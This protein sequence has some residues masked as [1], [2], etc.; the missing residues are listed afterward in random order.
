[1]RPLR[2]GFLAALACLI[3]AGTARAA[4]ITHV[5]SAETDHPFAVQISLRWDRA[6]ER[7]RISRERAEPDGTVK[8]A[9]ELRYTRTRNDLVTRLAVALYQDLE[10]HAELPQSLGDDVGWRYGTRGGFSVRDDSTI[11]NNAIDAMGQPCAVRPCALFP[12]APESSVFHGGRLG[13]LEIG[14]AW[15]IFNDRRDDTKPTWVV[16]LDVTL[17]TASRYDPASG[18]DAD[19]RSPYAVE[20]HRGPTGEKVWKWDLSTTLSRRIGALDPYFRAHVTGMVPSNETYSNCDHAAEL[21][22]RSPAQMTLAGSENCATPEWE[23]DAD[24]RL[25]FVAGLTFGTELVPFEDPRE[26]QKV[27]VDVRLFADYTSRSRFYNELT[28]ASGKLHQTEGYLSMG[29]LLGLRL[30]A[31]KFV[32]LEASAALSTRTAH[33]LSGESLGRR[34]GKLPAGD[35]SGATSNPDLNPN[36]DWRY[37]A[38]GNRFRISEVS[39]FDLSVAGVLRF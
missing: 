1:M 20:T 21:A 12:V 23:V 25:P 26:D 8:D 13:D 39:V 11:E 10:L 31:S 33:D 35:L 16:G 6:A 15:A 30:R 19:W 5:E 3:L 34:G 17:P 32:S 38:P 37:D 27:A 9:T 28:D 7:A 36:F 18:R 29:G 4:E 24:A 22:A 2:P 14:L